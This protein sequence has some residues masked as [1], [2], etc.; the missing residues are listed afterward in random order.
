MSLRL[1]IAVAAAVMLGVTAPTNAAPPPDHGKNHSDADTVALVQPDVNYEAI[2]QAAVAGH[3]TGYKGLPPG[4]A[5]N[6][7][8]G[9][10][11]PPGIAKKAVPDTLVRHLPTYPDSEWTRCGPDL[12]LIQ[13]ATRVVA[14]VLMDVFK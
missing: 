4:I 13:V 6:L 1:Y 11:L 14:D 5:K 8:R 2:R 9:K 12:V 10:P 7:A 3:Y